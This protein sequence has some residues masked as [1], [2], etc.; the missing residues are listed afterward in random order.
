MVIL[1]GDVKKKE[2]WRQT[3]F[4]LSEGTE[5][6]VGAPLGL[7]QWSTKIISTCHRSKKNITK[8]SK[9]N[10]PTQFGQLVH[11]G[12]SVKINLGSP[13]PPFGQSPK[14]GLFFYFCDSF[15]RPYHG[16][17]WNWKRN[18]VMICRKP[19][20]LDRAKAAEEVTRAQKAAGEGIRRASQSL[21]VYISWFLSGMEA[22]PCHVRK[23]GCSAP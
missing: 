13:L 22:S 15:L 3:L 8:K 4:P 9:T 14:K 16:V 11:F 18:C 21:Q 12:K 10:R 2:N 5:V 1:V 7:T 19:W 6:V 23:T 17:P 20:Q